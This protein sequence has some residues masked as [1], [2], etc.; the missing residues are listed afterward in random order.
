MIITRPYL[1]SLELGHTRVPS[2]LSFA[3]GRYQRVVREQGAGAEGAL[4][5]ARLFPA[6][7]RDR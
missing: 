3:I 2:K 7:E 5:D 4:L 1:E 6:Y